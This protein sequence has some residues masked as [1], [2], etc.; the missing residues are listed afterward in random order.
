MAAL[1]LRA[2]HAE[3][4]CVPLPAKH[5]VNATQ[6]RER[7]LFFYKIVS[8]GCLPEWKAL[9]EAEREKAERGKERK[10]EEK[11]KER[12][13]KKYSLAMLCTLSFMWKVRSAVWKPRIAKY[14]NHA[15]RENTR[16]WRIPSGNRLPRRGITLLLHQTTASWNVTKTNDRQLI[17]QTNERWKKSRNRGAVK[18]Y[19]NTRIFEQNQIRVAVCVR[20]ITKKLTR[21]LVAGNEREREREKK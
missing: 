5:H 1:K 4:N 16:V 3:W 19:V 15:E 8:G 6:V 7:C 21:T 2:F 12:E 17:V 11:Q 18:H 10:E 20:I 14:G 9:T 13:K